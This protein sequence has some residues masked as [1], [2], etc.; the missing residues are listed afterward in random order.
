MVVVFVFPSFL[1]KKGTRVYRIPSIPCI[2]RDKNVEVRV[3]HRHTNLFQMVA[4]KPLLVCLEQD[5]SEA[6]CAP[7]Q[8][9]H[10]DVIG[11]GEPRVF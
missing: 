8:S 7:V 3:M 10:H 6:S 4:R 5:K 11:G 2:P 9:I 1:Y